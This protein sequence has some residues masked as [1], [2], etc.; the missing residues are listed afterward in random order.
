MEPSA[1]ATLG[2]YDTV[3]GGVGKRLV[4][5]SS[6]I[7]SIQ[8]SVATATTNYDWNLHFPLIKTDTPF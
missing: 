7:S 1:A 5:S 8:L 2:S 4:K 6:Y 3:C